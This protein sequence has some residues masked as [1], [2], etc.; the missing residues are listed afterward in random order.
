MVESTKESIRKD[1][2]GGHCPYIEGM[3][4]REPMYLYLCQVV[5]LDLHGRTFTVLRTVELRS[6]T[7]L[8]TRTTYRHCDIPIHRF[9]M[10]N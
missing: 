6:I 7:I 4:Y 2:I 8:A 9:I 10:K 1:A 5:P 3:R